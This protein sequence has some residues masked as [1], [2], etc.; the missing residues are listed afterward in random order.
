MMLIFLYLMNDEAEPSHGDADIVDRY[1]VTDLKMVKSKPFTFWIVVVPRSVRSS[2]SSPPIH[3]TG[4]MVV[5]SN[6]SV[7]IIR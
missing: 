6:V 4:A 7:F 3:V 5:L 2:A 1:D